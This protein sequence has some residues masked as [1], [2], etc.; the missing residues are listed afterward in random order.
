MLTYDITPIRIELVI[1]K[2]NDVTKPE[3]VVCKSDT[4]INDFF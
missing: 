3:G 1:F 2:C 4:E